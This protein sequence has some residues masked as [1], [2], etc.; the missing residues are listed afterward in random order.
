MI[1][2]ATSVASAFIDTFALEKLPP[3][4]LLPVVDLTSLPHLAARPRLNAAAELL[5]GAVK[6]GFGNRVAIRTFDETWT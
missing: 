5:D 1:D 2:P 3:P 4:E 6:R